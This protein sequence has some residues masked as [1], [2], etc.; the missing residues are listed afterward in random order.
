MTVYIIIIIYISINETKIKSYGQNIGLELS[1]KIVYILIK[2]WKCFFEERMTS[3][4][5]KEYYPE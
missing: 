5:I 3:M 4:D 2:D 1:Y